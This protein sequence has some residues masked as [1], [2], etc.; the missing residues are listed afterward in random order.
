[1]LICNSYIN[2]YFNYHPLSFVFVFFKKLNTPGTAGG[3]G[4]R[5]KSRKKNQFFSI[6]NKNYLKKIFF[7]GNFYFLKK[8]RWFSS[9]FFDFLWSREY[10]TRLPHFYWLMSVICHRWHLTLMSYSSVFCF[11][12]TSGKLPRLKFCFPPILRHKKINGNF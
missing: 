9:V 12:P 5:K 3:P 8:K 4:S 6:K 1:M 11:L 7:S 2:S 10:F